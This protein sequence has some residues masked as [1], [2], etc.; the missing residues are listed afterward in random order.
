[1]KKPKEPARFTMFRRL[2]TSGV[3]GT[4]RILD[5]IVFPDGITVIRWRSD[6]KFAGR[7]V[8]SLGV[9]QSFEDFKII[10]ISSHVENQTV[11]SWFDEDLDTIGILG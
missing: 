5:G 6:K 7:K 11:I 8:N 10:H 9:F 3:S 4:G 1:M 2:D